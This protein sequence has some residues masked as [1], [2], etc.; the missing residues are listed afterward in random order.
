MT[1]CLAYNGEVRVQ[2]LSELH[3]FG[4]ILVHFEF[5]DKVVRINYDFLLLEVSSLSWSDC[6]VV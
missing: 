6:L 5:Y 4:P 3:E 1:V 2:S